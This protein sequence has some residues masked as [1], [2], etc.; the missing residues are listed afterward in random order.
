MET[1]HYLSWSFLET[2]PKPKLLVQGMCCAGALSRGR[3]K[4]GAGPQGALGLEPHRSPGPTE[5]EAPLFCFLVSRGEVDGGGTLRPGP[6][7]QGGRKAVSS[8]QATAGVGGCAALTKAIQVTP[9]STTCY[10][11]NSYYRRVNKYS[12]V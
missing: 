3:A 9:P 5:A 12:K 8:Q 6:G 11:S 7:I 1:N 2:E 4:E 10:K